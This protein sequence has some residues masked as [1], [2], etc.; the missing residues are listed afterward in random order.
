MTLDA[1]DIEAVAV[2]VTELMNNSVSSSPPSGE[3]RGLV[4]AATLARLLGVSRATVYAKAEELGVIRIGSGRRARL[5]FDPSRLGDQSPPASSATPS[6]ASARRRRTRAT[7]QRVRADLLP[8]R[9]GR[10]RRPGRL[11]S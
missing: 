4:D 2:R 5:R 10:S 7:K 6:P 1:G 11:R 9:G 8:I 3:P